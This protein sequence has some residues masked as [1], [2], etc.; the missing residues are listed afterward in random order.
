MNRPQV[1]GQPTTYKQIQRGINVVVDLLA[2]TLGPTGGNIVSQTD[3]SERYELL[4][5][6]AVALR[7]VISLGS[8]Q[9]DIGAMTVRSMV[10]RV[11]QRAGD[12]GATTAVLMRALFNEGVRQI[13]AGA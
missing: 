13:A 2:P 6:S 8:P 11:G 1:V 12:G 7:R 9:L 5:D 10:W 4:T 3:R